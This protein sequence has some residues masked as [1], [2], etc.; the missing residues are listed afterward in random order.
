[1]RSQPV[2]EGL[3]L[4]ETKEPEASLQDLEKTVQGEAIARDPRLGQLLEHRVSGHGVQPLQP[5]DHE[6]PV[7]EQEERERQP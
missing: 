5:P 1:M 6:A 2:E 3:Q 4:R 7:G